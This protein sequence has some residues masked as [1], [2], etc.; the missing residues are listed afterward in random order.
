MPPP[1]PLSP[2]SAASGVSVAT[3]FYVRTIG[4]KLGLGI[5]LGPGSKFKIRFV[6][7]IFYV[8]LL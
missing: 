1:P 5:L 2:G 6:Q 7:S 4:L 8:I 3:V